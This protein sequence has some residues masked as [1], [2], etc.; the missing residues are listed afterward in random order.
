[1]LALGG[2]IGLVA[3]LGALY[4]GVLLSSAS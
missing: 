4:L 3:S 2:A 1:V